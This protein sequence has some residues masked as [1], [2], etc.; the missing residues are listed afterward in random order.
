M[1]NKYRSTQGFALLEV[2]AAAGVLTVILGALMSTVSAGSAQL[3]KTKYILDRQMVGLMIQGLVGNIDRC[4]KSIQQVRN[5]DGKPIV[6]VPPSFPI[7]SGNS[8]TAMH[9]PEYYGIQSILLNATTPIIQNAK[10][11][12][13]ELVAN[14]R[15]A[16]VQE[17]RKVEAYD[18]AAPQIK[19]T[20]V[21]F[22]HIVTADLCNPLVPGSCATVNRKAIPWDITFS[23]M[24]ELLPDPYEPG[25]MRLQ[26]VGCGASQST[27]EELLGVSKLIPV[28]TLV[29]QWHDV[30]S[31][32]Q[33]DTAYR[34]ES[35]YEKVISASTNS[36][37]DPAN[38]MPYKRCQIT[39]E[40]NTS[41]GWVTVA[42]QYLN[43]ESGGLICSVV[44]PIGPYQEYRVMNK[45]DTA[46]GVGE[47]VMASWLEFRS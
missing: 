44:A 27:D 39:V 15:M 9:S 26:L 5:V 19:R 14:L 38:G 40:V 22:T 24:N 1:K 4:A 43:S 6:Q 34:N 11:Y 2:L 29:R 32:R 41:A 46:A 25:T 18:P 47:N 36:G 45:M 7:P 42:N 16:P 13:V 37:I 33:F 23:S 3:T 30:K 12:G 20:F 10:R 21:R 17:G 31:S 8:I 28:T 35:P